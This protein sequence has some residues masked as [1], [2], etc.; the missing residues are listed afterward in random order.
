[1]KNLYFMALALAGCHQALAHDNLDTAT[2]DSALVKNIDEIVVVHTPKDNAQLKLSPNAFSQ[3]SEKNIE[4][5]NMTS[6]KELSQYIPNFMMADYGSSL[7]SAAYIRGIGSRMNTPAIGLYVNNVGYADKSAYDIDLLDIERVDILRGPQATLYGGN[8]M[9][10]LMRVF[11]KDPFLYQGTEVKLGHSIQDRGYKA[12]LSHYNKLSQRLALA[13]SANYKN[14][15]GFYDN[16]TRN[17]TTGGTEAAG[18]R[19]RLV[20]QPNEMWRIDF[21]TD[22]SYREDGAYPYRYVGTIDENEE[23]NYAQREKII[24]GEDSYYRRSL[25]N[26]SLNARFTAEQFEMTSVTA[27]QNLN[28]HMKLDQDFIADNYF[29]LDQLQRSNTWSEELSFKSRKNVLWQWVA[30]AYVMH[31]ELRTKSP[32]TLTDKFMASVFDKANEAMQQRGMSIAL[33][34]CNGLTTDGAFETPLTNAALFHQSS[35]NNLFGAT[36]LS[37]TA[38]IRLDYEKMRLKYNYGGGMGYNINITSSYMPLNFTGLNSSEQLSGS[39]KHDYVEILPKVALQYQIDKNNNV[40]ASWSKGYRSGG[41]NIQM[42]SDLV[43]GKLTANMMNTLRAETEATFQRP[44]YNM[45]PDHVQQMILGFMPEGNFQGEASQTR[46][47]P[48]Y[49]YNYEVGAHLTWANG[50]IQTNTA[51]FYIDIYDQQIS[52]F[53]GSGL[54]RQM[55]NAGR[56][57]SCGAEIDVQGRLLN[58]RLTWQASYGYTHATFKRY[59]EKDGVSYKDNKVPFAPEHTMAAAADYRQPLKKGAIKAWYVG[60]STTGAGNIYWDEAN[61]MKQP[62]YALLHAHAGLEFNGINI[63]FWGKNLTNK[64]YDTFAFSSSATTRNIKI[65]QRANPLQLGFDVKLSF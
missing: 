2:S 65:A 23:T 21:S 31:Q 41:Y 64:H 48:E 15:E 10:G 1:M 33:N 14:E 26:S 63:E 38:G 39:L 13:L 56:G 62:F 12:Q 34:N 47:K 27:F 37:L 4:M 36:G 22:Y 35:F 58:N 24:Y 53:A 5:S 18:G 20:W 59:E 32:V 19:V 61:S 52:R 11:T 8:T 25:L 17:E 28:D 54:G 49:S 16:I 9:G 50:L 30:G 3:I 57:R 29:T 40:Y 42:F 51:V 43:Q 6:L 60:A 45:M 55:V 7:T 44:P 46:Y